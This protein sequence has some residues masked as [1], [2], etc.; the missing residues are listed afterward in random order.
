MPF[1]SLVTKPWMFSAFTLPM[2]L[3]ASLASAD[4]EGGT[5]LI[6][7]S[8]NQE[9]CLNV[10]YQNFSN[11]TALVVDLHCDVNDPASTVSYDEHDHRLILQARLWSSKCMDNTAGV[12]HE[13]NPVI[14]WDCNGSEN[15]QWDWDGATPENVSPVNIY[16]S[17]SGMFHY[18]P[19]PNMCLSVQW[20]D[21]SSEGHLVLA[22]CNGQGNQL[23]VITTRYTYPRPQGCAGMFRGTPAGGA[24][25]TPNLGFGPDDG[26]PYND[27]TPF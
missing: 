16:V 3:S 6:H 27:Q 22:H 7:Q 14:V 19:N 10:P 25:D 17:V 12:Q 24:P 20:G 13:L 23:F 9:L 15:Q 11:G 8:E 4:I 2:V 21:P 1:S 26:A 18:H 5:T